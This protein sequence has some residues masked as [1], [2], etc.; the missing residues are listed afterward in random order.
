MLIVSRDRLY[1]PS[2][3]VKSNYNA[4]AMTEWLW[5]SPNKAI[6]GVPYVL[7]DYRLYKGYHDPTISP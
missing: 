1:L 7:S 6:T 2:I 3:D 4:M 5:C